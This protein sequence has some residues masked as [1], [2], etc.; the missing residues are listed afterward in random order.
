M[1]RKYLLIF[2]ILVMAVLNSEDRVP[3]GLSMGREQFED[4]LEDGVLMGRID[5][6]TFPIN[7]PFHSLTSDLISRFPIDIYGDILL[8]RERQDNL[9]REE[10]LLKALNTFLLSSEQK[11]IMYNSDSKGLITLINDSYA[12]SAK[13]KRIDNIQFESLPPKTEL[14]VYQNDYYFSGN[15]F[16]YEVTTLSDGIRIKTTN[17]ST[18]RV[19]GIFKAI[20]KEELNMEFYI[21]ID[22]K[23]VCVYG[24][25]LVENLDNPVEAFG[26]RVDIPSAMSKRM[27]SVITWF[28]STMEETL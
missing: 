3:F 19:K 17:L 12:I 5:D 8:I 28:F 6:S 15:R 7:M 13:G 20:D 21:L 2:Y 10:Y 25:A 9:E 4:L 14:F 26:L 1:I 23:Y 27:D 11:G 18:M 24:I 16:L 22:D